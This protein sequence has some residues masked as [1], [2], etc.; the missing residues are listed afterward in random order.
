[1][2]YIGSAFAKEA[3]RLGHDVCLFDSLIFEQ[4]R[5]R[6]LNEIRGNNDATDQCQ[7][8]LGDTRNFEFLLASVKTFA[9][10]HFMHWGDLSS[11]YS[12]NHNPTLTEDISYNATVNIIELC[13]DLNIPLFYNSTSSVYGVQVEEKLMAETDAVPTPTDLYTETKLRIED[14]IEQKKLKYPNFKAIIFRPATVFG[15]S[16]RFRIE[17]LPNHFT[18]MGITNRVIKVADLNAYRA[19]IDIEDL[20]NGYFAVI[21]KGAWRNLKYNIGDHNMSKLEFAIG[22][23]KVSGCKI[24][25]MEDIGDLRNL[26]IDCSKFKNEFDFKPSNDYNKSVRKIAEWLERNKEK[27]ILRNFTEMLNMPLS[28]WLKISN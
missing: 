15:L 7:F 5:V 4:D 6:I 12:C 17:L 3:L 1:M 20:I 27:I 2:G 23:Q 19:A 8:I 22:I 11:V 14:Y 9:P 13:A 21:N 28:S 25:T 26:Q 18:W 10:T 16:P 24:V